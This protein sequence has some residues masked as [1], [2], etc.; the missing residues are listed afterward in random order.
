VTYLEESRVNPN[1]LYRELTWYR[2][3]RCESSSCIEV[4]F[5][6]NK[7]LVRNSNFPNGA[8][9]IFT[10]EEWDTFTAGAFAGDFEHSWEQNA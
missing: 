3:G 9:L 2:G 4:A 1:D 7:V 10:R 8:V 6:G 5:R